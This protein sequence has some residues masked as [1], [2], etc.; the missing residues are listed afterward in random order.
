[1]IAVKAGEAAAEV[2]E[3]VGVA[4]VAGV[5]AVPAKVVIG[6]ARSRRLQR[7]LAMLPAPW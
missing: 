7:Q 2:A 1:M 5:G 4:V 3:A 6:V